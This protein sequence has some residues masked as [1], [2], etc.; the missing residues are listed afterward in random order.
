M[1]RKKQHE[2]DGKEP[3]YG[4]I[5]T[6]LLIPR[7]LRSNPRRVISG[8]AFIA[9]IVA[10]LFASMGRS[11]QQSPSPDAPPAQQSGAVGTDGRAQ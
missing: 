10:F 2:K 5:M 3:S 11:C 8:I 9:I 4:R 7:D 6:S 1:M